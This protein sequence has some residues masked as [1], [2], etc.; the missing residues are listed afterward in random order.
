MRP[1]QRNQYF[2][3]WL[4]VCPLDV[5]KQWLRPFCVIFAFT[6]F[7][8]IVC[9]VISSIVFFVTNLSTD[10]IAS[11]GAVYQICAFFGGA[12]MVAIALLA[13]N[14]ITVTFETLE[15]IYKICK[16]KIHFCK[17]FFI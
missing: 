3:G 10:L 16:K 12:Y 15:T 9:C 7:I 13:R 11:L 5:D 4:C 17:S 14:T 2:F 1:M 6:T 8:A